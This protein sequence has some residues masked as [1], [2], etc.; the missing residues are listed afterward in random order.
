M[1][2][3]LNRRRSCLNIQKIAWLD[4]VQGRRMYIASSYAL[5]VGILDP[6]AVREMEDLEPGETEGEEGFLW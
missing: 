4:T 1:Y 2:W 5:D 6:D 3:I